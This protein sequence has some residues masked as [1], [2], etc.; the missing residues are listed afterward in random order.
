MRIDRSPQIWRGQ[1]ATSPVLFGRHQQR[2][3]RKS[4]RGRNPTLT[5]PYVILNGRP[6]VGV[7]PLGVLHPRHAQRRITGIVTG[8]QCMRSIHTVDAKIFYPHTPRHSD[9]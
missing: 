5:C 6:V 3:R 7:S 4:G 2:D 1:L 8:D 9:P